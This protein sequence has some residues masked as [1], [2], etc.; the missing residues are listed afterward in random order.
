MR[1]R[2][3]L[4]LGVAGALGLLAASADASVGA[5]HE[6]KP[7]SAP[8]PAPNGKYTDSTVLVHVPSFFSVPESK[9]VDFVVHFHGHMTTAKAAIAAHKLR[10]QLEASRQNAVLVVPQGPV[11]AADGDFGKLMLKGGLARL[12]GEV[13]RQVPALRAAKQTGR[14]VL[15]A[16]SGGYRAAAACSEQGGVDVREIYLFDSLYGEVESFVRFVTDDPDHHKLVSYSVGGR[17]RELGAELAS[18][19]ES[20]GV[21]VLR[22]TGAKKVTRG[23][24]VDATAAFLFGHATHAS[25]TY[26]ELALRDCLFASCLKGKGSRSWHKKRDAARAS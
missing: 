19:L 18:R 17:P 11:R 4:G 22:E 12:L 1:R 14:V 8:Y 20:R 6:L 26:E 5:T 16:H 10:E 7:K 25:A 9:K 21:D 2:S 15:S 24:L 23:E 13:R 3:F